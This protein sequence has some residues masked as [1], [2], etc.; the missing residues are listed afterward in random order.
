[1]PFLVKLTLTLTYGLISRFL[2]VYG[3]YLLWGVRQVTVIFL[4]Y[5][6]FECN[7]IIFHHVGVDVVVFCYDMI[8][9]Q[10]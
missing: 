2:V 4:V 10:S 9:T 8:F 7:K 6:F 3:A 1:M 5:L